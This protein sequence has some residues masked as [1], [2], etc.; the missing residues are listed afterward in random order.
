M[1]PEFLVVR[2]QVVEGKQGQHEGDRY[3]K[4]RAV[5]KDLVPWFTEDADDLKALG[6]IISDHGEEG[7]QYRPEPGF[8]ECFSMQ[9]TSTRCMRKF[10]L[11]GSQGAVMHA[12]SRAGL[13]IFHSVGNTTV[14]CC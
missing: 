6:D 4:R 1:A 14:S 12:V 13:K 10:F 11:P 5:D 9:G 7:H 3:E 2:C 8:M